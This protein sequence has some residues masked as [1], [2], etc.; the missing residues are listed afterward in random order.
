VRPFLFP[1]QRAL[2]HHA[3]GGDF[4]ETMMTNKVLLNNV[5]HQDLRV[6]ARHGA[7]HGDSVNQMLVFPTEFEA[8][9]R[10]YPIL[11]RRDDDGD[12]QAVVLLGLDRDENLFLGADGSWQSRHVPA[13]AARG[14][15]SIG[16]TRRDGGEAGEPMIHIDLDDARVGT[17]EGEPLFMPQGG[18]APYLQQVAATL[19]AIYDGMELARAMF[20][21]LAAAGL[22]EPV[23]LE[24]ML[25]ETERYD[26]PDF[27]SI[28][29]D[30][31]AALDGEALAALNRAGHLRAAFL[32]LASVGNVER[33]IALKN[34]KKWRG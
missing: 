4:P 33:L 3:K 20:D 15:F 24:V 1:S 22:I 29:P 9:Q 25:S 13:L 30:R 21:A 32:A 26:L 11:F 2:G 10:E 23:R 8:L 18:N 31:L 34:A 6:V 5:A 7:E 28:A 16:L 17:A 14:P 12:Y 19:G 27:F